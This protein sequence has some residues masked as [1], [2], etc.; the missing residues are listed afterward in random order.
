MSHFSDDSSG[1]KGDIF[2]GSE[3]EGFLEI[4]I[5]IL[6]YVFDPIVQTSKLS[7]E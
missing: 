7:L 3:S 5:E 4:E 2:E 6:L 1:S